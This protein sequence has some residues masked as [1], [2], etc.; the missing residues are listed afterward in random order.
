[1]SLLPATITDATPQAFREFCS[2]AATVM[3]EQVFD[4][5]TKDDVGL[6][7]KMDA[8]KWFAKMA[9]YEPKQNV[10]IGSGAGFSITINIPGSDPQTV[11]VGTTIDGEVVAEPPLLDA[12]PH[13]KQ[14]ARNK[15]F[16]DS[17]ADTLAEL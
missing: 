10:A 11:A 14:T 5:A 6:T 4:M 2:A 8:A 13:V 17:L 9:D 1:M 15:A 7:T 16:M 12:P 3:A